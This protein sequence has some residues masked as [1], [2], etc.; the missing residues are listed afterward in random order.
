MLRL[1]LE[2]TDLRRWTKGD[3]T[4]YSLRG[5]GIL[6]AQKIE[7]RIDQELLDTLNEH[8]RNSLR[9]VKHCGGYPAN[10]KDDPKTMKAQLTGTWSS[11]DTG[12]AI[13]PSDDPVKEFTPFTL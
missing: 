3:T 6:F 7:G 11:T 10:G 5:N 12:L 4:Y 2:V 9:Y 8:F 13:R 1:K